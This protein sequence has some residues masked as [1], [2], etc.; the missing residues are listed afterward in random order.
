M[1]PALPL[2]KARG[3]AASAFGGAG[4]RANGP[5]PPAPAQAHAPPS[6]EAPDPKKQALRKVRSESHPHA[7]DLD[8]TYG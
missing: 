2:R 5:H 8:H 1:R 6:H 4:N 3:A 7:R